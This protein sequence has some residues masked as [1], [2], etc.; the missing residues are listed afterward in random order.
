[1]GGG[2]LGIG[3]HFGGAGASNIS[4][5]WMW[6]CLVWEKKE[7]VRVLENKSSFHRLYEKCVILIAK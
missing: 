2:L 4:L 6:C 1:M 3:G 7:E 5:P